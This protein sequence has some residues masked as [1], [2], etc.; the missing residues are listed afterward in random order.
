MQGIPQAWTCA[1]QSLTFGLLLTMANTVEQT[2][3]ETM[4]VLVPR[5]QE[6]A[7]A[8]TETRPSRSGGQQERQPAYA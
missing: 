2:S 7:D 1:S 8:Q 3:P 4:V 5:H 6:F